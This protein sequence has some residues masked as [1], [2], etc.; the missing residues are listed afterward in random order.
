M[1][2]ILIALAML[3]SVAF[4]AAAQG[5]AATQGQTSQVSGQSTAAI[6]SGAVTVQ[7][8]GAAQLPWTAVDQDFKTNQAASAPANIGSTSSSSG[9]CPAVDGWSASVV[10]ANGGKT[11]AQEL[12]GCMLN[13]LTD[14]FASLK[15][16]VTVNKDGTRTQRFDAL[17]VMKLEAWCLFPLYKQA[18][19]N[20]GIFL[21]KSTREEQAKQRAAVV[22]ATVP[23]ITVEQPSKVGGANLADPYI[24]ERMVSRGYASK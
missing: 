17:S 3:I 8:F 20:G 12:P 4:P 15:V 24:A 13:I 14:R 18:I 19:E 2:K 1:T 23:G 11:T 16:D 5:V 21:C 7:S 22:A 6:A 9:G 10:V